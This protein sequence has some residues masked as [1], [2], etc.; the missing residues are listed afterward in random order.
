MDDNELS[1][2]K[3]WAAAMDRR[4][5]ASL[6]ARRSDIPQDVAKAIVECDAAEEWARSMRVTYGLDVTDIQSTGENR[7]D[8]WGYVEGKKVGIELKEFVKGEVLGS[9]SKGEARGSH[10]D[11]AFSNA[12]W[13]EE[14]FRQRLQGAIRSALSKYE[15]DSGL[16]IDYL[17]FHSDEPYLHAEDVRDW[18]KNWKPVQQSVIGRLY[19]MLRGHPALTPRYPVFDLSGS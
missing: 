16:F 12:L 18:L 15:G 1:S 17:V 14:E 6:Y 10:C 9:I 8:C 3:A 5:H 11:P 4:G 2:L 7:P 19:L 13:S